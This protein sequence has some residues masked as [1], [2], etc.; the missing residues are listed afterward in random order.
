ML[1]FGSITSILPLFVLACA[2][3]V[4]M[5][6]AVLSRQSPPEDSVIEQDKAIYITK[7]K[8]DDHTAYPDFRDAGN[9]HC[10]IETGSRDLLLE[11]VERSYLC[12]MDYGRPLALQAISCFSPRPPPV[13]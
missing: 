13:V 8:A 5:G 7:D 10:D 2:Y 12:E 3:C 11:L 1:P 6:S 9:G 4:Y